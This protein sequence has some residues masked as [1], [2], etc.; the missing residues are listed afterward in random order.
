[1]LFA[2]GL[3]SHTDSHHAVYNLRLSEVTCIFYISEVSNMVYGLL[4]N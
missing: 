3:G 4:M 2:S 1:M